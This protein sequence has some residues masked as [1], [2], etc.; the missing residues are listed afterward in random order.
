MEREGSGD[1]GE[2]RGRGGEMEGRGGE[3]RWGGDGGDGAGMKMVIYQK[4]L[5]RE[6]SQRV[7]GK[8]SEKEDT[9]EASHA[10]SVIVHI[11]KN[12]RSVR[13]MM[14]NGRTADFHVEVVLYV[15]YRAFLET[16]MIITPSSLIHDHYSLILPHPSLV[17]ITPSSLTHDHHSLILHSRSSLPHPSS[18]IITSSSLTH[19]HHSL[20]PH[21]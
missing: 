21:S 2:W 1:G 15:P 9:N 12:R 17:I 18:M 3:G 16:Y 7:S 19:D 10:E 4:V 5:G 14:L 8:E 13:V 6:F 20:I 11:G